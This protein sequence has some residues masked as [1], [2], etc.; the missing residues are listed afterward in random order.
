MNIP[1]VV[2][3]LAISEDL[4]EMPHNV[5]FHQGMHCLLRQNR[6]LKKEIQYFF[7]I[8]ACDPS[9]YTMDHPDFITYSFMARSTSLKRV[10]VS[11]GAKIR[12]R[13]N[14]APHLTQDTYG[15]VTNLQLDTTNEST[16]ISPFPVGDHRAQF[17][18]THNKSVLIVHA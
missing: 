18:Q 2:N 14:K 12:N 13:Y 4:D 10:K 1:F 5:A 16:K 17:K 11:K 7:G 6:P 15:T 9:I 8:I 3:T